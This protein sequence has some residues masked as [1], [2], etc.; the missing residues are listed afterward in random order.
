[1]R[2][3][4]TPPRSSFNLRSGKLLL[5]TTLVA[6]LAGMGPGCG[7]E[8]PR[9]SES[10]TGGRGGLDST[11][12]ARGTSGGGGSPATG[13]SGGSAGGAGSTTT[14]TSASGGAGGAGTGGC[15]CLGGSGGRGGAAGRDGSAGSAG[16]VGDGSSTDAGVPDSTPD[17]RG[18]DATPTSDAQADWASPDSPRDQ[19][20]GDTSPPPGDAGPASVQL[21]GRF[22]RFDSTPA[23]FGWVGSAMIARFNGTGA[24]IQ[25]EGSDDRYQVVIDGTPSPSVLKV[26]SSGKFQ[27]AKGLAAGTH[28]L[29]V[30]RRT[31]SNWSNAS[32]LGLTVSDGQLVAPP[33]RPSHRIE[34]Y[35]DSITAGYGLDGQGPSCSM[36]Q[37]NSNHYLTYG[38]VAARKL[39]AELHTIA[40]SGIGMYRN[41]GESA[42]KSDSLT[43]PKVFARIMPATDSA[44][45]FATWQPDAVV[46]NL[47]T[48]D[49]STNGDPGQPY[50]TAYLD[51]VRTLRKKYPSAFFVLTVGPMLDGSSLTAI[52]GHVQA[53]IQTCSGEGDSKMSYLEFPVQTSADGYGCDWHPS[54]ATNAKMADLLVTELKK[55]LS[56]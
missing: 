43:M 28:D 34:I 8:R 37:D 41:Y 40:W 2:H 18:P 33:D 32:Y 50:R 21:V 1:M 19:G 6:V 54:A 25:L 23:K 36:T 45:D 4:R 51:F 35:G 39:S 15:N 26:T 47:G 14:A 27:V 49:A 48:N 44:W 7:E 3:T 46:I 20:G 17:R 10:G 53:V 13:G 12:D 52:R 30:W 31:E 11:D 42:P 55:Q 56:W 5:S 38:A 29:V 24:T 9:G 16:G 22:D